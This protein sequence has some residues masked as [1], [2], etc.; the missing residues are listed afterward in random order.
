MFNLEKVLAVVTGSSNGNG[1][2]ISN[3]LYSAGAQVIGVDLKPIKKEQEIIYIR[4]DVTQIETVELVKEEI[5]KQ[6]FENLVLIN[7][8]GITLPVKTKYPLRKWKKTIDV[9]LTAPFMWMEEFS[10]LY[11]KFGGGSIINITSLAATKAFPENPSY[12]ASKGGLKMLS[13]YYAKKLGIHGTRVNC[14]AP[15]YIKTAMTKKSYINNITKRNRENHTLLKRWGSS[16]DLNGI[17]IFLSS[18]AS[19][20]ITGQDIYVDGGWEAN[21]LV[22]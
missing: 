13:K 2:S 12:I 19:S 4:G 9:N 16:S 14:V 7:N 8:A 18:D 20:Y 10:P 3:A 15:G 22:E 21:G 17:C 6:N 11:R 1:L 5:K